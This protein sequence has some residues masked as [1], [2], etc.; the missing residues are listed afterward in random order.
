MNIFNWNNKRNRKF[1]FPFVTSTNFFQD[2]LFF[3][4]YI[5]WLPWFQRDTKFYF[6]GRIKISPNSNQALWTDT[7]THWRELWEQGLSASLT[8]SLPLFSSP[9][10]PLFIPKP[11]WLPQ[12]RESLQ[13][14]PISDTSLAILVYWVNTNASLKTQLRDHLLQ[15]A[16]RGRHAFPCAVS[17][18]CTSLPCCPSPHVTT[19]CFQVCF[20]SLWPPLGEP[21]T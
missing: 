15:E 5:F 10:L 16:E 18:P 12:N 3:V 11:S 8:P 2:Y 19:V 9:S 21:R 6:S 14:L 13:R 1:G 17:L 7:S 4:K 20:I